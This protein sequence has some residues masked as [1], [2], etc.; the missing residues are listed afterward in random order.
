MY[1]TAKTVI[2]MVH[3]DCKDG[4]K[5]FKVERSVIDSSFTA[6]IERNGII[7]ECT[8]IFDPFTGLYYADDLYGVI[9]TYELDDIDE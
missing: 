9:D 8:A 2:G 5:H 4:P 1:Q 7:T 3:S 6:Y